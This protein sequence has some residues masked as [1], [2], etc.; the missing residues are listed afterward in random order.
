MVT[1]SPRRV[2]VE[3]HQSSYQKVTFVL[4]RW[5]VQL[6]TVTGDDIRRTRF[7]G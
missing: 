2:D 7:V 4:L 5:P 3:P 6:V 1:Q